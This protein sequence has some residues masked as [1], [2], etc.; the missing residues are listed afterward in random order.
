MM[1]QPYPNETGGAPRARKPPGPTSILRTAERRSAHSRGGPAPNVHLDAMRRI[2]R[3]RL[4]EPQARPAEHGLRGEA[5][6][7]GGKHRAP[8]LHLH[9]MRAREK[10]D[11]VADVPQEIQ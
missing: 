9:A 3:D 4:A 8:A 11:L 10:K 2:E 6:I 1:R 5:R 7:P